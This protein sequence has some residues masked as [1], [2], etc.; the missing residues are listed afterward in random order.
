MLYPHLLQQRVAR[1]GVETTCER[2]EIQM[3]E[4]VVGG[5]VSGEAWDRFQY[6]PLAV[7]ELGDYGTQGGEDASGVRF[8]FACAIVGERLA[9][10]AHQKEID[11]R[12]AVI[13]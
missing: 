10:E 9:G 11:V 4:R 6:E 5:R 12:K 2:D 13:E 3:E 7:E 8:T 1:R